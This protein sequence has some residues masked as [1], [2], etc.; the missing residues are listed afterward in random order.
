MIVF[1]INLS[2]Y[3]LNITFMYEEYNDRTKIRLDHIAVDRSNFRLLILLKKAKQS[4]CVASADIY[5]LKL[6]DNYIIINR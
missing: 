1:L 2:A 4:A 3:I 6:G 5:F